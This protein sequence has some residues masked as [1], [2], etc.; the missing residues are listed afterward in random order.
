MCRHVIR[1][2]KCMAIVRSIF[3]YHYVE[4]SFKI[5]AYCSICI[6]IDAKAC[7]SVVNK[8]MCNACIYIF[9]LW[10]L[11]FDYTGD[12]MKASFKSRK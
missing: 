10:H 7:R 9:N 2:F 11:R 1:A 12:Q 6:L 4:V 3:R 8:N 5:S